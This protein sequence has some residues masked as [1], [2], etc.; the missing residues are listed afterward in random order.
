MIRG[1]HADLL[2]HHGAGV[3]RFAASIRH[4]RLLFCLLPGLCLCLRRCRRFWEKLFEITEKIR[5]SLE[6]VG[7]LA[8]HVLD[9][10]RFALV[11]LQDFQKLLVNIRLRGKSVLSTRVSM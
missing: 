7:D 6:E 11:S 5:S 9:G 8:V 2:G 10:L 3:H 4:H 1:A